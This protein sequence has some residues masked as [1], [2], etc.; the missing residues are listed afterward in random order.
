MFEAEITRTIDHEGR[1]YTEDPDDYGGGTKFGISKRY[2][3]DVDVRNLTEPQAVELYRQHFYTERRLNEVADI[4]V[5]WKL[6]DMCV[7][8]GYSVA[9]RSVQRLL[10]LAVDGVIG[11]HTIAAINAANSEK[12][13][14]GL[15]K[16]HVKSYV[17]ATISR[18][19]NLKYLEGWVDRA[20][21]S[22]EGLV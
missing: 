12:L 1:E 16:E 9:A 2:F 11:S 6:F 17:Y 7:N 14:A 10:Y 18:P 8:P 22:G 13:L 15:V 5:R 21:D 19:V 4:R 20:F 3:P